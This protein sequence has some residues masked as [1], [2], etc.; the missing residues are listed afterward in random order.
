MKSKKV[1]TKQKLSG[2][3]LLKKVKN[4]PFTK[5]TAFADGNDSYAIITEE[6]DKLV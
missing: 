5:T 6:T 4:K 2:E 3:D 1:A